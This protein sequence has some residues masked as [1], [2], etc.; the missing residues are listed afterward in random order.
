MAGSQPSTW[1][2]LVWG[3]RASLRTYVQDVGGEVVVKE[4]ATASGNGLFEFPFEAFE[5]GVARYMGSVEFSAHHG[6]INLVVRDPWIHWMGERV[7]LSVEGSAATNSEGA[8]LFLA[9]LDVA[10]K[11]EGA[12]ARLA[13]EAG[14]AFD[15]RY[16]A[17]TALDHVM[18]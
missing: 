6:L 12:A 13:S 8:R 3:V 10:G 9:D 17:G 16:P 7:R 11:S 14:V 18:F 4:P 2:A 15:F 1:A 5:D